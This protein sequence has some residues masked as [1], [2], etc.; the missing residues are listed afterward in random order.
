M[1]GSERLV[2]FVKW[3]RSHHTKAFLGEFAVPNT[4][5]GKAA[6]ENMLIA[7]EQDRDVWLGFTWWAAG[8]WWGDYMFTLEPKDGKDRP[9]MA[10]LKPHLQP[11]K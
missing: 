11:Q 2:D 7:M 4:P 6:L 10:W 8:A 5:T 1:I 9:Q 3:C